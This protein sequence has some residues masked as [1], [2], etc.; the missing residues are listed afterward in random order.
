M[1]KSLPVFVALL[2]GV[3]IYSVSSQPQDH[4]ATLGVARS[5]SEDEIKKVFKKLA[6][7]LHPDAQR[8]DLSAKEKES[9]RKRFMA[10]SDA[11]EVLSD[12]KKREAYDNY[13]GRTGGSGDERMFLR[14]NLFAQ[15]F[16]GEQLDSAAVEQALNGQWD[17]SL[18]LFLWSTNIP[19]CIDPGLDFKRVAQRLVGSSVRVAAMRCDDMNYQICR[20][21]L[22]IPNLPALV[23][24][25]RRNKQRK[26][27][28]FSG[29]K[30]E[31][32]AMTEFGAQFLTEHRTHS[33]TA[34]IASILERCPNPAQSPLFDNQRWMA[35]YFSELWKKSVAATWS[36]EFVALEFSPCF[37]CNTELRIAIESIAPV[38]P[39]LLVRKVQCDF[40]RN[41]QLCT[42]LIGK[43]ND[44]AW[45]IARISQRCF[46]A[47]KKPFVFSN[48]ECE[49][50]RAD[51]F[52][53]KY[54][55]GEFTQFLLGSHPSHMIALTTLADVKASNDSYAVLYVD[56][57]NH[58]QSHEEFLASHVAHRHWEVLARQ[59]NTFNP[60]TGAKGFRLH[61]AIIRCGGIH[62]GPCGDVQGRGKPVVAVYPFGVK[63][64]Q[65]AASFND[66]LNS[67]GS[68]LSVIQRDMEP[69]HLHVLN[70]KGWQDK[71][72]SSLEKGRKWLI[73]F[74][75]GQW[76]P[77]C[78]QIRPA[79]KEAARL[80]QNSDTSK[81]LSVG[82]V[83]CD[84]HRSVCDQQSIQN[85]PA[86]FLYAK[87][88]DRVQF[89][90]NR[91]A[92]AIVSWA[93]EAMDSRLQRLGF[94]EIQM[95]LQRSGTLVLSF[96]AGQWCPPC[97]QLSSI[98]KQVANKLPNVAISEMNCDEDQWSCNQFGI[99]GYPTIVMFHK[100]NRIQFD[101]N[102]N[103]D[104]IVQ[105]I[106]Q[107][108]K[109]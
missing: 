63:A 2:L 39:N 50:V 48:E 75:A 90:G 92:N 80:I 15:D 40:A 26:V 86:I 18:L 19:D 84:E 22:Q 107:N 102:K 81:R 68:I 27:E 104:H 79:W 33:I 89:N 34:D 88:R 20:F 11:Y 32:Q 30:F 91:E 108:Q 38:M 5:A 7:K 103:V 64:K 72:Q 42:D 57:P 62:S 106:Q 97:M 29:Q 24:I 100:G 3:L 21:G 44:R 83:E 51:I 4:Y 67:P 25:K 6:R 36:Y 52:Q 101:G 45:T 1:T 70:G 69:L 56:A 17:Q 96:T 73:L 23:M 78:N 93:V 46:Y 47:T 49:M 99:Q 37:D 59:L 14:N 105:W 41:K 55:S 31:V 9:A 35:P 82:V 95:V 16:D 74:N 53:G 60:I 77:P 10:V 58:P 43:Q 66:R 94:R 109:S 98:Y 8:G 85:Y 13:G 28:H 12:K 76:C 54:S 65:T 71:V 61:A 87:G